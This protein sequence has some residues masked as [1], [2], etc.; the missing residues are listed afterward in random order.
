LLARVGAEARFDGRLL[1]D[2]RRNFR[3]PSLPV[4]TN[5]SNHT[6]V[7][8]VSSLTLNHGTSVVPNGAD[9]LVSSSEFGYLDT[10]RNG[11]LD[12]DESMG[13]RPVATVEPVG[14][15]RVVAVGDPSL[16]INA[17]LKRSGN[18]AFVQALFGTHQQVLLDYSHATELPPLAV[19]ML[20][21]Q[22]SSLL[23]LLVGTAV[24][25]AIV[26]W[27]DRRLSRGALKRARERIIGRSQAQADQQLA[28]EP[29]MAEYLAERHPEWERERIQRLVSQ[30]RSA[31]ERSPENGNEPES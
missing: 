4:A 10:N 5:V 31:G 27:G 2:E 16:F 30:T 26:L 15:G 8:N 22:E 14:E 12:A 9:V 24:I 29:A 18:G 1:R 23:Q 11:D 17:M 25:G 7:A 3:S 6:L 19:V 21:L 20:T 28:S 13:T